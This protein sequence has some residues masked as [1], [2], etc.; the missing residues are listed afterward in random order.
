MRERAREDLRRPVGVESHQPPV[1]RRPAARVAE[2]QRPVFE[3]RRVVGHRQSLARG[4]RRD[5]P[6]DAVGEAAQRP[7]LRAAHRQ[8]PASV[9]GQPEH[10]AERA[11]GLR[12]RAGFEVD[13]VELPRLAA[14]PDDA[15]DRVPGDALG[16]VEVVDEHAGRAG[17]RQMPEELVGAHG[18]S[19]ACP[20]VPLIVSPPSTSSSCPVT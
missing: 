5:T 8:A 6:G 13:A 16:M 1:V 19:R 7:V 20:T 4:V 18:Q 11:P 12:R 17:C 10:E 2:E 15:G 3:E 14:A 9:D